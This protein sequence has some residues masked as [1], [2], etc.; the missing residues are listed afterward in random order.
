M[1]AWQYK[2]PCYSLSQVIVSVHFWLL[3]IFNEKREPCQLRKLEIKIEVNSKIYN[4]Y[5]WHIFSIWKYSEHL[6]QFLTFLSGV[7]SCRLQCKIPLTF[8]CT[9]CTCIKRQIPSAKDLKQPLITI[10]LITAK[11]QISVPWLRWS[12]V[13]LV[14]ELTQCALE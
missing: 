12:R 11:Q 6:A 7:R 5:C 2:L 10:G 1:V 3:T 4:Y 13:I 9:S 14:K 8:Y